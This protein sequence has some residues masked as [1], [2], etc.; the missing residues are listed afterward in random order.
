M[1][2]AMF[3]RGGYDAYQNPDRLVDAAKPVTTK[4]APLIEAIS[5][6][7]PTDTR[8]LVRINGAAQMVGG[9]LLASGYATRP[10]AAVLA[11]TMIPTTFAAHRY[12]EHDDPQQRAN[13][14][15]HFLKN[16]GIL[17][18]LLLAA[19]DT[20]GR[21]G[22]AWRTSHLARRAE[23]S[24]RRTMRTTAKGTRRAARTTARETRLAVRAARLG[25]RLPS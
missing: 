20:Q 23:R 3:V 25:R 18:G 5:P 19:V 17:G 15:T 7:L 13:Q 10:A 4:V 14:R 11:A 24:A 6:Q 21:P 16:L 12:W 9:V 22:L 8:E 1:L 2:A